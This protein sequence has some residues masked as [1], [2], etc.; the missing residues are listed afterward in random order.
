M[1]GLDLDTTNPPKVG[2]RSFSS[3]ISQPINDDNNNYRNDDRLNKTLPKSSVSSGREGF[4]KI[5]S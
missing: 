1:R 4:S 3:V 5:F 2:L